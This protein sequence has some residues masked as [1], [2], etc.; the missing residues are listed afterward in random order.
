[1]ESLQLTGGGAM[2]SLVKFGTYLLVISYL[3]ACGKDEPST[4]AL[5]ADHKASKLIQQKQ[6]DAALPLYYQIL[7]TDS[8][9]PSVHSNL[10]ILFSMDKKNDEAF[11]SLEFALKLAIE[12]ADL[13]KQFAIR[14][15]LGTLY[16][17]Q[18]KIAEA[19]EHYQAALEIKP[20]SKETKHN[21]EL[22][23]ESGSSGESSGEDKKDQ[24][25]DGDGKD[26]Q[27]KEGGKSGDQEKEQ[28]QDKEQDK[29]DDGGEDPEKNKKQE[30]K[31]N[32]KYK[33][34]PF[35]GEDLSEGDVKKI[36]GELKNQEQKIRANFEK[37][38]RK[39][40]NNEKDW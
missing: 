17:T 1:M 8:A 11:K 33:P 7:E 15:N 36:L 38:E 40:K 5:A 30:Y 37:K 19:L 10:G 4:V 31:E 39:D 23:I 24:K 26:Q 13:A 2:K 18:K 34:R 22:L 35:K 16:G 29:K 27:Q 9:L 21:I 3:S 12:Q 6:F 28:D 32:S 25:G 20:D 14:F